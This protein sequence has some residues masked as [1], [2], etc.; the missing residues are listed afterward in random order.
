MVVQGN[1]A[2]L[3]FL[4]LR[5]GAREAKLKRTQTST[6][7]RGPSTVDAAK[8]LYLVVNADFA[9]STKPFTVAGLPRKAKHGHD[10]GHATAATAATATT[11]RAQTA[12]NTTKPTNIPPHASAAGR[13]T[14]RRGRSVERQRAAGERDHGGHDRLRREVPVGDG[15]AERDRDRGL[16][17][18]RAG[19]VADRQRVLAVAHPQDRVG[20]LRQLGGQRREHEREHERRDA[21]RLGDRLD[22]GHEQ[23]GAA[24]D[25]RQRDDE[26]ERRSAACSAGRP[27]CVSKYSGSSSSSSLASP[28]PRT[29]SHA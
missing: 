29:V 16:E 24:D 4:K 18:H 22:R 5:H 27:C 26:L 21:E 17:R 1:P 13:P 23:L 8:G 3:S 2:Q 12:A 10:A 19:D 11:T 9:T 25:R 6:K 28:P 20:L 14:V 15:E 7:L